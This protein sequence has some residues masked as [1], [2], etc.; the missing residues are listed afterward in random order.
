MATP[1]TAASQLDG[2]AITASFP[3][4]D[5]GCEMRFKILAF[6]TPLSDDGLE[7]VVGKVANFLV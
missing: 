4:P 5:L 1:N 7:V 6:N 2:N 3:S